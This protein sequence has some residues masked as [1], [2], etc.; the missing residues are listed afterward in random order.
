MA[1]GGG[2]C[3]GSAAVYLDSFTLKHTKHNKPNDIYGSYSLTT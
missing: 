1:G 2:L 3:I